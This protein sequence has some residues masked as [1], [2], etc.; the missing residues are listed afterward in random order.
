R[1]ARETVEGAH[2]LHFKVISRVVCAGERRGPLSPELGT[3]PQGEWG[4]LSPG[5]KERRRVGLI[6]ARPR[7]LRVRKSDG[8]AVRAPE[9]GERSG[10]GFSDVDAIVFGWAARNRG[11]RYVIGQVEVCL[12]AG[13]ERDQHGVCRRHSRGFW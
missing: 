11:E 7:R 12:A 4:H 8:G 6:N 5:Y 3:A 13:V 9:R 2:A 1:G 10:N